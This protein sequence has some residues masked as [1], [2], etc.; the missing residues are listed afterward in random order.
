M[1]VT[2]EVK[3]WPQFFGP[4]VAGTRRH[5]LRRN[6]R[7]Y[8]VGDQVVLRE[9]DPTDGRYTGR[10]ATAAITSITSNEHPCAVSDVGLH[11][12]F[13]ILTIEVATT[14]FTHATNAVTALATSAPA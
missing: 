11:P 9:W 14:S 10:Q 4:V 1:S 5:E 6:D 7:G 8:E 3:S 12:D 13:C 2:H